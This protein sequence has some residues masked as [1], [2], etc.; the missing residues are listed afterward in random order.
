MTLELAKTYDVC[1]AGEPR[2]TAVFLHGIAAS[3][4]SFNPLF[5]YLMVSNSMREIRL[6]SFD[7]LGA[8][9]SY[10]SDALNYDFDEQL[11]A[12]E[13]SIKKLGVAGPMIIV[14]H[15]MGTMIAARFA[16]AHPNLV[17][18]LIL[19]SAPIYRREDIEN[20][21]FEKAMS[22]FREVVSKKNPALTKTKVFD[23]EIKNIVSNPENYDYLVKLSQ[24]TIMIYGELDKIIGTPNIAELLKQN[25]H[26]KAVKAPG[27][28]GVSVDK[29]GKISSALK[30]FL[31]ERGTK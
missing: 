2:L 9:K 21:L 28:H 14:A 15:S 19:I 30:K 29:F 13:N 5:D 3:S 25:S 11:L 26:I 12:L 4:T 24:P 7:L 6:V 27:A 31:N 18:G 1:R 20:P 16:D 10:A 8:G 22:G 23:S 17:D